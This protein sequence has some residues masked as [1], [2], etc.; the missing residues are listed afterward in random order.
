M[1]GIRNPVAQA[2]QV[3]IVGAPRAYAYEWRGEPLEVGDWVE[4]P[5]NVVSQDGCRGV[6]EAFGRDGYTGPLKPVL[7]K[8]ERLDVYRER[9]GTVRS[10]EEAARV[11]QAAHEAG[12]T[13]AQLAE[14]A[15]LGAARLE[16]R[17]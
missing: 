14:L 2:V 7:A 9:M 13:R 12:R 15:E 10:R 11:W 5:G 3:R 17:E 8:L 1:S 4:L 6:V 16:G